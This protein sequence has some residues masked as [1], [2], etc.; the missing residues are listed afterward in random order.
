MGRLR[1]NIGNSGERPACSSPDIPP[2][3]SPVIRVKK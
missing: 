3:I 1:H 2:V